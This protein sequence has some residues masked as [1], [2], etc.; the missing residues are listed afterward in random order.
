MHQTS[1]DVMNDDERVLSYLVVWAR[2]LFSIGKVA[3]AGVTI[4]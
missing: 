1:Y 2:R 4:R 3:M